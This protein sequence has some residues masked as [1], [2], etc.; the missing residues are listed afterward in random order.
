MKLLAKTLALS[1]L[2]TLASFGAGANTAL[3]DA[4][5]VLECSNGDPTQVG[6][7]FFALSVFEDG[8]EVAQWESSYVI[9]AEFT[10]Y[11][12]GLGG[13]TLAIEKAPVTVSG[14]GETWTEVK[15]GFIIFDSQSMVLSVALST[16]GYG[17]VIHTLNCRERTN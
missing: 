9:D 2:A 16:E 10:D 4:P 12:E 8:L 17:P 5:S 7:T 14:E 15:N 11:T 6:D 1:S 3:A 13:W